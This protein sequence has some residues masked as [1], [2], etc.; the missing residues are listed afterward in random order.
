MSIAMNGKSFKIQLK[1]ASM[2]LSRAKE[3][4]ENFDP[5]SGFSVEEIINFIVDLPCLGNDEQIAKTK[6][7]LRRNGFSE[8]ADS[9]TV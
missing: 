1:T 6:A 4:D 7:V 2:K 5:Q 9:F 8:I 3:N